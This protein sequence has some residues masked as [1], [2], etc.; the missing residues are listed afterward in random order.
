[1]NCEKHSIPM[2]QR[3]N[4]AT[5]ETTLACPCCDVEA[6]GGDA[7]EV[8]MIRSLFTREEPN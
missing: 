7:A 2:M 3:K 1:M 6:K 5:G 4:E 8:A